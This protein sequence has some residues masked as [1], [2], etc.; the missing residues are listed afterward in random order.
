MIKRLPSTTRVL[1]MLALILSLAIFAAPVYAAP[2]LPH[3]FSGTLKINNSDAPAGTTVEAR[4]TGVLT[5]VTGNPIITTEAGKYGSEEALG[6]KLV[7]QGDIA[8]G[9]TIDFYVNGVK[10]AQTAYWHTGA[11]EELDLTMT[12]ASSPPVVGGGGGALPTAATPNLQANLFGSELTFSISD[13]GEILENIASISPDGKVAINIPAGTIALDSDGDPLASLLVEDSASHPSPPAGAHI[14]G[15]CYDFEPAGTTFAP[16]A[17]LIFTY[18]DDDIPEGVAEED[19]TL[20]Y[21]DET[22]GE[23]VELPSVINKADNT[24]TAT[25][26]H[27]TD[28]AILG[29]DTATPPA[30]PEPEPAPATTPEPTLPTPEPIN[31]VTPEPVPEPTPTAPTPPLPAPTPP[32][33]S[34]SPITASPAVD[35]ANEAP[36]ALPE[37]TVESNISWPIIG[38][39]IAGTA[40]VGFLVF[41]LLVRRPC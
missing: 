39:V 37:Q 8:D 35:T 20:A 34:N 14:I 41:L 13:T 16:P 23:W 1:I 36:E 6:P 22:A 24:I 33:P 15:I 3:S 27:F 29:Y 4:G 19:L 26:A 17:S 21:Y 5:G 11:I 9:A 18:N 10:A 12:I 38:I 7:V 31:V 30:A 32:A 40:I 25:A 28:F 2:A